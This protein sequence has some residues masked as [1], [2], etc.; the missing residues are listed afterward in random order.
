MALV[1]SRF[2][3]PVMAATENDRAVHALSSSLWLQLRNSRSIN[4]HNERIYTQ[5]GATRTVT[6][7]TREAAWQTGLKMRTQGAS[8]AVRTNVMM[9]DSFDQLLLHILALFFFHHQAGR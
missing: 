9:H 7:L 1:W 4:R 8:C 5:H 2:A 3:D 6:V